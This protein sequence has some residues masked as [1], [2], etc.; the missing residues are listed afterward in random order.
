MIASA[1]DHN[2]ARNLCNSF[3]KSP[4]TVYFHAG[5][6]TDLVL[7]GGC[8]RCNRFLQAM[9]SAR[10]EEREE[11]KRRQFARVTTHTHTF[12]IMEVDAL[13]YRDIKAKLLEAGYDHAVSEDGE[14][15]T[16]LDMHGI[17]L[18]MK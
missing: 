18:G 13:I 2:R 15:G 17:A 8:T 4:N 10:D 11:V 1:A 12:V 16:L 7:G 14:H 9:R 6:T 5:K 3:N